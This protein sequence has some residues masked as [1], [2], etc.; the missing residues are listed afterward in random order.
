M[1]TVLLEDQIFDELMELIAAQNRGADDE[2]RIRKAFD[3]ARGKHA[4]QLRKSQDNYIIHP[5]SVAVILVKMQ[6]D[7][8]SVLAGILHD[9]IEDTDATEKEIEGQFDAEIMHLVA[10]VTKLG[11]YHFA[12]ADV[13]R[14]AENFRRM[15]IAMA[16]DIRV[17]L[18]K[19][20]DRLHNMRTLEHLKPEKQQ[21]ISNETLEIFAPLADRMGMGNIRAELEDLSLRYIDSEHYELIE[22]QLKNTQDERQ[23]TI[24]TMITKLCDQLRVIGVEPKAYGRVKN[25]YSIYKKIK[26]SDKGLYDIYDISA[27]RIVVNT[28]REC[29]EALGTLHHSYR[30]IPGRFKDYIAMPKDNLYQSL[31][32]TVIGPRGRPIE[33]QI[34]TEHMHRIAEYGIAAHWRYKESGGST[35]SK[36]EDDKKL[37]FLKQMMDMRDHAD[38]AREYVDT[39]RLDLFRE[40]VFAF[41]PKGMVIDLPRGSTPVDFAYR[42]HTEIGNTC[43]GAMVNGK[44]VPLNYSLHNG[45][46]IEIITNKKSTP[47]LDWIQFVAT[48]QAK[49]RI[50]QWYKKN[51]REKHQEQ[52]RA[53]LE[54]AVT[55]ATFEDWLDS[56]QLQKASQELNYTSLEDL[57]LGI[58]FGEMTVARVVSR[59][60]QIADPTPK[61][62]ASLK[63]LP[64]SKKAPEQQPGSIVEL[65]G[66]IYQMAK[67]CTPVPGEAIMGIVTRSRGVMVHRIDCMNLESINPERSMQLTWAGDKQEFSKH[68]VRLEVTVIDRVGVFKDI[69][70]Q[71]AETQTNLTNAKVKVLEDKTACIEV[72]IEVDDLGHLERVKKS[73]AK[74][75]DVLSVKRQLFRPS[76][77]RQSKSDE[78]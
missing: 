46:I 45:D 72:A 58:G 50:R 39:I 63:R 21:R 1:A 14:Q 70:A 38:T 20:A 53:M 69:L 48:Q 11:K 29:Y 43:A 7:T 2:A 10:G 13:D 19:L 51:F 32:S 59:L 26:D 5:V 3:Y 67:C 12:A 62:E 27:L 44:I 16:E 9:T 77:H 41:S 28:E 73:V 74:V 35:S 4:G 68:N 61:L 57:Y 30:P 22:A 31:H 25:Y 37:S 75:P 40:Q 71:I 23:E 24:N 65:R 47:R 36:S 66:M 76:L 8:A 54:A 15:F 6:V 42:I 64:I 78:S 17:I 56:G 60:K 18:V 49:A 33:V 52:G 34:R 55:K